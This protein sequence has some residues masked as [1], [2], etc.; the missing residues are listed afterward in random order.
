M[1]VIFWIMLS[2]L[3]KAIIYTDFAKGSKNPSLESSL[4]NLILSHQTN[5]STKVVISHSVQKQKSIYAPFRDG[6]T[7]GS[8]FVM[9]T[10]QCKLGELKLSQMKKDLSKI[11]SPV[12]SQEVLNFKIK[13]E[14]PVALDEINKFIVL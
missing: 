14:S 10:E 12:L 11:Y 13:L 5:T 2:V 4:G 7:N 6:Q 8:K 9:I 3:S 1:K